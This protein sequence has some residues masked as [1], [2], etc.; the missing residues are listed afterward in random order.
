MDD[1]ATVF[2]MGTIIFILILYAIPFV[3]T[4]ALFGKEIR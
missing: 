3:L 4:L 1:S 2:G